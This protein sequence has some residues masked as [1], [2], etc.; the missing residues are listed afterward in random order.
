M[1]RQAEVLSERIEIANK[2]DKLS[3]QKAVLNA[4][5]SELMDRIV[6]AK[7]AQDKQRSKAYTL[8]S[9]ITRELL[10]DDLEREDSFIS[11]KHL[12]FSFAKERITVDGQSRFAASSSVYLKNSFALGLLLASLEDSKFRFPRLLMLVD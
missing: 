12:D 5:R 8:L 3:Q 6:A 9:Q 10:N 2:V 4:K 11:A 7:R 1:D